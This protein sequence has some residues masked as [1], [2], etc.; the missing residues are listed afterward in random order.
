MDRPLKIVSLLTKDWKSAMLDET[1]PIGHVLRF[2]VKMVCFLCTWHNQRR[3]CVC[4]CGS[5]NQFEKGSMCCEQNK[6][7]ETFEKRFVRYDLTECSTL[8]FEM[9]PLLTENGLEFIWKHRRVVLLEGI[10]FS[11]VD[12]DR[13]SL[14]SCWLILV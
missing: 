3:V 10:I 8:L 9:L 1:K 2:S 5:A 7:T 14:Q 12:L 4:V 13:L 11:S 6:T